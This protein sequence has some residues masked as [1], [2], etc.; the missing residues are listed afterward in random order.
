M[1]IISKFRGR[2][3][4]I[5]SMWTM[6]VILDL[7]FGGEGKR[8]DLGFMDLFYFSLFSMMPSNA[9]FL[10]GVYISEELQGF[11]GN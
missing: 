1:G 2:R 9:H 8:I 11:R 3:S 6:G 10:S 7:L 5:G 4:I